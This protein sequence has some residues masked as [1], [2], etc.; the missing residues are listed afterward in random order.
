MKIQNSKKLPFSEKSTPFLRYDW[1]QIESI[2]YHTH[3]TRMPSSHL[4]MRRTYVEEILEDPSTKINVPLGEQSSTWTWSWLRICGGPCGPSFGAT[5]VPQ[6]L[7]R[8]IRLIWL[9][10]QCTV[11]AIIWYSDLASS[12]DE[13]VSLC[14]LV[15]GL[16]ILNDFWAK[17]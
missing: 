14:V 8:A 16:G 15:K 9:M 4:D 6:T 2:E 17:Q 10:W 3:R 7:F 5:T 11:S 1:L 12:I 13:T